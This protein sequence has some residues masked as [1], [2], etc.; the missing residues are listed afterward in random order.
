MGVACVLRQESRAKQE[1]R[2]RV[3][4]SL[5]RLS[6]SG[7]GKPLIGL[8]T[9]NPSTSHRFEHRKIKKRNEK[10][11]ADQRVHQRRGLAR[12]CKNTDRPME[13]AGPA[14]DAAVTSETG[15]LLRASYVCEVAGGNFQRNEPRPK[16]PKSPYEAYMAEGGYNVMQQPL[17]QVLVTTTGPM[18][19]SR[20]AK[21]PMR[22][23]ENRSEAGSRPEV[24]NM[25]RSLIG[26]F[27]A[28]AMKSPTG[29][30]ND[31]NLTDNPK[32]RNRFFPA[33]DQIIPAEMRAN[34]P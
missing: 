10:N 29:P 25:A 8:T 1:C 4:R 9:R 7:S 2:V 30:G 16:S 14:S 18:S 20:V 6:R 23:T 5:G 27:G 24:E 17:A 12:T 31:H 22:C 11:I 15:R 13:K 21:E 28:S 33:T 3:V 19:L 32:R 34:G 26:S